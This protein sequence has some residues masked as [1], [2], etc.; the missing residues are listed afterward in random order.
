[1]CVNYGGLRSQNFLYK[2]M[3]KILITFVITLVLGIVG[4]FFLAQRGGDDSTK[5]TQENAGFFGGLFSGDDAVGL[6]DERRPLISQNEGGFGFGIDEED[7]LIKRQFADILLQQ[8]TTTPVAGFVSTTTSLDTPLVRYV[9]RTTGNVYES[10]PEEVE[11]TRITNTT[12]PGVYEAVWNKDADA[13]IL[14]YLDENDVIKTFNARIVSGSALSVLDGRFL[15]DDIDFLTVD[16]NGENIFYTIRGDRET[17]LKKSAFNGT[18]VEIVYRSFLHELLFE[19]TQTGK[20]FFTTKASGLV[21][22]LVYK[23]DAKDGALP[24]KILRGVPGL[25]VNTNPSGGRFLL[26]RGFDGGIELFSFVP[27]TREVRLVSVTTLPEKCAWSPTR[28]DIVY[29]GVPNIISKEI[30]PDSWYQ[31]KV[32]FSDNIWEIDVSRDTTRKLT[33]LDSES[34]FAIDV[35]NPAISEFGEYLFFINKKDSSLW[36]LRLDK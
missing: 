28:S 16:D 8:L 12:I 15:P 9:E 29:C 19:I 31:G 22:G 11:T 3:K 2:T 25:T 30:Y 14:R 1:V 32:S 26:S 5:A 23:L 4:G 34:D 24:E 18:G 35:I 10:N 33:S 20:I 17:L 27:E 21:S 36:S 13:V 7:A 6:S